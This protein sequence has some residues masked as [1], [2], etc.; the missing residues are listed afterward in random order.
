MI[1][2]FP[3]LLLIC[4]QFLLNTYV[5]IFT[6]IHTP[7][8]FLELL[9]VLGEDLLLKLLNL[10][11]SVILMLKRGHF[12]LSIGVSWVLF[13]FLCLDENKLKETIIDFDLHIISSHSSS[14]VDD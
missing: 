2:L 5:L 1:D 12:P 6:T 11:V 14:C 10:I 3:M 4:K 8:S 13:Q 9:Q 7:V